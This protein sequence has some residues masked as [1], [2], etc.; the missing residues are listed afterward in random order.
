MQTPPNNSSAGV[1]PAMRTLCMFAL[2]ILAGCGDMADAGR[3]KP[4]AK[5]DFFA[6]GQSSR[7]RVDGT[8]ARGEL[9]EDEA[10]YTGKKAGKL[11][12]ESPVKLSRQV[13]LRGQSEYNVFCAVCHGRD[14]YGKGIVV[15]RGFPVSAT[16]HDERVR[17]LPDGHFFD[18]MTNG[19]GAMFPYGA[20]IPAEDR[21]AIVAYIR[22]LQYSQHASLEDLTPEEQH[23]LGEPP[24]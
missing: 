1:S 19:R 6:D 11:I 8:V 7:P 21:W 3:I 12:E 4:L 16:F 20:R 17:N 22:A 10:F 18:I 2:L 13:L 14:G 24:K 23:K 9:H 5:S 15:R